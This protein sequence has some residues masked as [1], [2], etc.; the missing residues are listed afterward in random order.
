MYEWLTEAL[1]GSSTVITANRR[2]ARVLQQEH[3]GQQL[4]LEKSAWESPAI[5][6]MRD[7]LVRMA[8]SATRQAELPTR[9]SA[10]QSQLL[11]ERCI[12][13]EFAEPPA[14]ITSLVRLCRDAWQRMADWQVSISDVARAAQSTDHRL[15]ATTAGRYLS[16]LEREEWVDDASL[17]RLVNE[18]LQAGR[19][20]CPERATFVGFDRVTPLVAATRDTLAATG[21]EIHS[22]PARPLAEH[23]ELQSF[24]SVEAEMR[25]AGAWARQRLE[26]S[27]QEA[28]AI[29]AVNLEQRATQVAQLVR[30]G[31]VPGWQYA[32]PAVAQALNASYGRKLSDYPA[33]SVALLVIAWLVRD[34]SSIELA[35]L[36][37]TSSLGSASMGGRTRLELKLRQLPDR[38]WTPARVSA[39][40][41]GQDGD[42]PTGEW[43]DM[44][45]YLSKARRALK[46][47]ASPADWALYIDNA[48]AACGWP[49]QE[50]LS[51]FDFQLV[52]RWRDMLNE[53]ARLDLV[54]PAMNLKTAIRRLELMAAETIFQPES[55]PGAV[56]LMGPL[57][58]S[59]AEFDAIWISGTTA[60]NWPPPGNPS[61]LLARSLQRRLGMPDAE[62]SDTLE[63]AQSLLLH[64][65]SAAR[66]VVCSYAAHDDDAEQSP[67][68]LLEGLGVRSAAAVTDP[69]WHA[70]RLAA[71]GMTVVARD[72]VPRMR[73]G[74]RLAGGAGVIQRQL[75]DPL[76][77]FIVGRLGVAY[78]PVQAVGLPAALRGNLIH[79]ALYR[80]YIDTPTRLEIAAWTEQQIEMRVDGAVR[81]AFGRHER[82][83][84]EALSQLLALEK[85]RVARLAKALIEADLARGE[86]SISAVE[87]E[88]T[89]QEAEV[90]LQLRIDR[91]DRHADGTL[92]ILDYKTGVKRT[93]L[94]S[95]GE[96][97]E[98]QL[99]AYA[100]ALDEPVS[101]MAL[102][103]VDSREV[104]FQGAGSGYRLADDWD[105]ALHAW[106]ELV[107]SA[108][109]NL[110]D[111]DVRVNA[112]QGVKDARPLNL[113]SRYT[114][115]VRGS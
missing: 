89:L 42:T 37:R 50:S 34:I 4:R 80:L 47:S 51:S 90:R 67:S 3:A 10:H 35:H 39:M 9:L 59:G 44:I 76:S 111:G 106:K 82:N 14:G 36:M 74:E 115:L 57:E 91:I 86:F 5:Y 71:P 88:V 95:S 45:A 75:N 105:S 107:R 43:L 2:L 27:P 96:P 108:C 104:S 113:L 58:A 112:L 103:N 66:T 1:R 92:E 77:A 52:N 6:S 72:P 55:I 38:A 83:T 60:A 31:L 87:Q 26:N 11:W 93:L 23:I 81:V 30:D 78:L 110:S 99:V 48:L 24:D 32:A 12:L 79:D 53:L 73:S 20:R 22:M 62:P 49:G 63:Y 94:D 54:S 100:L 101:A 13:K 33:V 85:K 29:I 84:D 64:L 69:G 21:T 18:L 28:I 68:A 114:E 46:A 17:G 61:P 56:Q 8:H 97:K 109:R 102:V 65:G 15:F 70:S 40:F 41:R 25:G 98:I 7:W 19:L 16:Y